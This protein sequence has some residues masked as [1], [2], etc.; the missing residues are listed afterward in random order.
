ME[1]VTKMKDEQE[2]LPIKCQIQGYL[3][4]TTIPLPHQLKAK[5]KVTGDLARMKVKK[6]NQ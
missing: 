4:E 2:R 6:V 5:E 3:P 1:A